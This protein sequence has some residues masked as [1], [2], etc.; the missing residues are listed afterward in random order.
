MP[1]GTRNH[2]A[3][4]LGLDRSDV[5][6]ALD[7]Y[8]DGIERRVDLATVNGRT[9]VNNCSLGLY[10]MV[11]QSPE[12]RDAKL[13]T[14]VDLLPD[15]IG[16]EAEPLDLRYTGPDGTRLGTAHLILVSN[17]PYQLA[18]PGGRGTRERL[19]TGQLGI[20]A[21]QVSDA[22]DARRFMLA[23]LAGQV[24]R[25][26][27]WLE[28]TDIAFE[29]DSAARSRSEST[30]RPWCSNRR[31]SSGLSRVRCG[32]GCRRARSGSHPRRVRSGCWP[33][34]RR[35]IWRRWRPVPVRRE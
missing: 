27:G 10:A 3:L 18:H 19:D 1:A 25:F 17:N 22:V 20:V 30:A 26:P 6:G 29:V 4:D 5:V 23:E 11:V 15:L 13:R 33:G 12:Y 35:R 16:P 7:A 24:Q 21:A 2:F 8:A 28:W 9:F 31:W 34:R 32:S 14:A